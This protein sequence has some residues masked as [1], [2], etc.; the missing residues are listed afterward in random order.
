MDES[1]Q[2]QP[3]P[4]R[5]C[6]ILYVH[7]LVTRS[8]FPTP[9]QQ[10]RKS[11]DWIWGDRQKQIIRS[12][13]TNIR[14]LKNVTLWHVKMAWVFILRGVTYDHIALL[15]STQLDDRTGLERLRYEEQLTL[16]HWTRL[17]L[18]FLNRW[19]G[20]IDLIEVLHL[21]KVTGGSIHSTSSSNRT[22][23]YNQPLFFTLTRSDFVKITVCPQK[24]WKLA[25]SVIDNKYLKWWMQKKIEQLLKP[26]LIYMVLEQKIK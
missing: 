23:K 17:A 25:V 8:V 22:C 20:L 24:W 18:L 4:P 11:V 13:A 3:G 15:Y 1:T 19:I 9:S 7:I 21:N 5:L 26:I 10:L 6:K 12:H 16:V 14:S 2:S